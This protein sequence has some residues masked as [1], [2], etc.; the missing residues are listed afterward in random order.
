MFST[1]ESSISQVIHVV[2]R[3]LLVYPIAARSREDGQPNSLVLERF[4]LLRGFC[5]RGSS[6]NSKTRASYSTPFTAE[7]VE[8]TS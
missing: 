7:M 8:E 5:F 3:E 4:L 2:D 1:S 6:P